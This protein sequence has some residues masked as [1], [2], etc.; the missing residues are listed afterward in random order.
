LG[1]LLAIA[2]IALIWAIFERKRLARA[3]K[4]LVAVNQELTTARL[5][6]ANEAERERRRIARD[7]H[8]Q[9]LAD[10]RHLLML[11]DKNAEGNFSESAQTFRAEIESISSEIRRICEDLSPSVLENIGFAAALRWALQT[12][13]S[14]G[15]FA[16]EFFCAEDFDEKLNLSPSVQIQIYRI[17]QEVLNNIARH[18]EAKNVTVRIQHHDDENLVLQIEDD[19]RGFEI[20]AEHNNK[21]RGLN[22]IR[23]RASLINAEVSWRKREAGGTIFTLF[24]PERHREEI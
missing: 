18:A 17:A 7:L 23:A 6:L 16:Y 10:L 1:F 4:R 15:K 20:N 8:D 9:T 21:G 11:S 24:K 12:A 2:L 14:E 13:A 3:G 19:G 22:N 5:D